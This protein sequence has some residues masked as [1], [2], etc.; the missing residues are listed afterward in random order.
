MA[1]TEVYTINT[2]DTTPQMIAMKKKAKMTI[3]PNQESGD[4]EANVEVPVVVEVVSFAL[5]Q[6]FCFIVPHVSY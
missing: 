3:G 1:T 6:I 4:V 5:N 2:A